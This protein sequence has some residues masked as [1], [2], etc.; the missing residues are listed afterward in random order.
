M[1][2]KATYCRSIL[3]YK[4]TIRIMSVGN[5]VKTSASMSFVNLT[6]GD[7]TGESEEF[8]E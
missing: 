5:F 6:K 1:I 8:A 7:H 2:K 4:I 3:G